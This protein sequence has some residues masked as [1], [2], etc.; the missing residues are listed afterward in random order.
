MKFLDSVVLDG[1]KRTEEGFLIADAYT[2]RTGIQKYA[3]YEVGRP[4]LLVVNV[5][6]PEAEVF[7]RDSLQSI[8]HSPVTLDHPIQPVTS[9]NWKDLA[10]GEVSTDVLRDGERLK[11]PLI[12]KDKAAIDAVEK[13]KRQL[14]AGYSCQLDW[15]EGTAPDGTA[16]QAVQ[17]N[18][19]FNH[20]AVVSRGR[21]GSDF[22][23]GDSADNWGASPITKD[24]ETM[25]LR[26]IVV[27]GI[28]IQVTDQGAEAIQKLNKQIADHVSA[29]LEASTNHTKAIAAKDEEIGG[30]KAQLKQAQ[31]AASNIDALIADRMGLVDV[32]S[33]MIKDFK[34]EGLTNLD[35]KKEVVKAALG[36]EA[37]KD[38]SEAEIT[39]MFKAV[40]KDAGKS[41]QT[42]DS[43]PDAFRSAM[44]DRA[45]Q[46]TNRLGVSDSQK[47][48]EDRLT[49]GWKAPVAK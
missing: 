33:K 43:K 14:S 32:A 44:K 28:S 18:I 35:I 8:T 49:G 24:S 27:D 22:R 34:P 41:Q 11:V 19:R 1:T 7:S 45:I 16:Y 20:V 3:G 47:A 46:P 39:G 5:Y 26:T 40:T 12:L 17:R 29:A 38:A 2:V 37:L 13:G 9:E 36:D 23:I 10:V 4:D 25:Q 6:R 31:D 48:Y 15:E 42:T 21:A 30:L